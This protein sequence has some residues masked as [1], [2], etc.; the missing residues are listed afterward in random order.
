MWYTLLCINFFVT[1]KLSESLNDAHEI[2]RLSETEIFRG[3]NVIYFII[4]ETF[5]YPNFSETL[6]GCPQKI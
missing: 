2:F 5:R 6:N 4:H 1:A 3:K